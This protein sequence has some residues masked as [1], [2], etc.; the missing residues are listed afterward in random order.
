MKCNTRSAYKRIT[1]WDQVVYATNSQKCIYTI[2]AYNT[3]VCQVN[4]NITLFNPSQLLTAKLNLQQ[5]RIDFTLLQLQAP[6]ITS[7]SRD[8]GYCAGDRLTIS[9]M[10]FDL[11]G[12]LTN[13]HGKRKCAQT[14]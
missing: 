13:Q 1:M 9:G 10:N 12:T 14:I 5:I 2:R 4:S 8:Y 3:K 11:C 6:T 7:P